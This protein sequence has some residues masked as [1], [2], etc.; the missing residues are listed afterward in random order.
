MTPPCWGQTPTGFMTFLLATRNPKKARELKQLLQ[1]SRSPQPFHL[2]TL[3]RFPEIPPVQEDGETFQANAVKKAVETSRQT[4]LPVLAEDS[5]LEVR[6]LQ[7]QP[8]VRSARYAGD[9]QDDRANIAKLLRRMERIPYSRRQAR[10]V[11]CLALGLGGQIIK[12]FQGTCS[13]SIAPIPR[14]K[15]GFGYDPVF[16][17]RGNRKALAQLGPRVKNSL[18]HRASAVQRFLDWLV[19]RYPGTDPEG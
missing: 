13:G 11:S 7:G 2:L 3:D 5:G 1:R 15:S 16:I 14:G 9:A 10:F 8:G 19:R 18:S 12:T 4:I 17:P 6:A